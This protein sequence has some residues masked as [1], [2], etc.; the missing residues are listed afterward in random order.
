MRKTR[1]YLRLKSEETAEHFRVRRFRLASYS[2]RTESA[3]AY[4]SCQNASQLDDHRVLLAFAACVAL[5]GN[6]DAY[7]RRTR[8]GADDWSPTRTHD[9]GEAS[10]C[11]QDGARFTTGSADRETSSGDKPV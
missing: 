4:R 5:D 9:S 1:F 2:A 11:R 8:R 6:Q 3:T 7:I 10:T